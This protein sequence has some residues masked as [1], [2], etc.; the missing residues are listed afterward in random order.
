MSSSGGGENRKYPRFETTLPIHF[1]LN[2]DYHYVP[3]IKK[4]GVGGTI[5]NASLEGL[6]IGAQMGLQDVFQIFA[7]DIEKDSPFELEVVFWDSKGRRFVI[8]GSVKWYQVSEAENDIRHFR[9][10]LHLR[11]DESRAATKKIVE[12]ITGIALA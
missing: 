5:L 10:G 4:L 8:R 9:A 3:A 1:N 2:P 7:E 11:D 12:S 6:G